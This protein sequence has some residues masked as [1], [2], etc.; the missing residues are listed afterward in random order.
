MGANVRVEF[1]RM[2]ALII[3]KD[4]ME[5]TKQA[6]ETLRKAIE[7]AERIME[8]TGRKLRAY[9]C[10]CCKRWHLS[11]KRGGGKRYNRVA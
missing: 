10:P 6:Y 7:V 8:K 4:S 9:P 2:L 1:I 5:C 11:S 3:E